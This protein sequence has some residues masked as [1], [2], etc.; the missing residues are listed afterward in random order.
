MSLSPSQ[1][2][3]LMKEIGQRLDTEQWPL[4]DLTLKQFSLPSSDQWNG[5]S[6]AYILKMIENA[7][8]EALIE[9]AQHLGFSL[10]VSGTSHI[11]PHFGERARSVS[12]YRTL[13]FKGSGQAT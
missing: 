2:V 13:R 8:D 11:E 9:L 3:S 7:S 6:D 12:S 1:R 5:G 10:E 4:I